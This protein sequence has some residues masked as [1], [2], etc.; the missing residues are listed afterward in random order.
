MKS[1]FA[2]LVAIFTLW[3]T[4][5]STATGLTGWLY[6]TNQLWG[7]A[8]VENL[9]SGLSNLLLILIG[10]H[11]SGVLFTSWRQGENLVASMIHGRK[12]LVT[13]RHPEDAVKP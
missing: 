3:G 8:W 12:P 1:L 7:V 2:V 6:T 11:I 13:K 5:P 4:S 9:H 10:L